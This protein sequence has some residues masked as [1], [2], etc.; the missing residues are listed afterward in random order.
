MSQEN[1][2]LIK[3]IYAGNPA[4]WV[5]AF[6]DEEFIAA[7]RARLEPLLTDD[8]EVSLIGP[9]LPGLTGTRSGFDGFLGAYGEWLPT[10]ASYRVEA[11]DFRAV[12]HQVLVLS[13]WGGCTK[14][15]GAEVMQE[16]ADVFTSAPPVFV[17]P[18]Q[19]LSTST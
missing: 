7:M 19:R 15:G 14:R 16:G 1:A 5:A 13:R 4:D 17:H 9:E 6:E 2:D 3:T 18:P 10:W 12:G 11:E 8:F